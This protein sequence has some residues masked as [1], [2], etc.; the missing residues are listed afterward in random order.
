MVKELKLDKDLV[1]QEKPTDS[2]DIG[3]FNSEVEEDDLTSIAGI[4]PKTAEKLRELGYKTLTDIATGRAD[5][6]SSEMKISYAVAK[7]WVQYAQEKALLKM[8]MLNANEYYKEKINMQKFIPTGSREF[9]EMLGGGIPT[10][11]ITGLSGRFSSGKTQICYEAVVEVIG[12]LKEKAVFIETE[13]DTF[14]LERLQE[15]ADA[16]GYQCNWDNLYVCPANQIP[17]AKAQYLQY[18]LV[19]KA[20]EQGEPIRLIVVDS[21]T[22]KFRPGYSRTEMLPI[23]TREFSEHFFLMEYLASKYNVAWLITCQVIGAPRPE[24]VL[25]SKVKYADDWYPVGGE[26][27]FHSVN[28]WISLH[29]IKTELWQATLFDSS[30]KPRKTVEFIICK[31]GIMDGVK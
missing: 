10:M 22:A 8:K 24:M 19:Q 4:G 1:K 25:Q 16:K 12:K 17:T 6:I 18:K 28:N 5:E 31:K 14:H 26:L 21:F 29:Q 23:R 27:L 2:K 11:S 30:W 20:L 9:N 13:P 3:D 7:T 15:M